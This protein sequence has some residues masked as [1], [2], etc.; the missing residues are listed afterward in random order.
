MNLPDLIRRA[1]AFGYRVVAPPGEA[2]RHVWV[3]VRPGQWVCRP[4]DYVAAVLAEPL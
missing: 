2:P 1:A 3:R 4:A